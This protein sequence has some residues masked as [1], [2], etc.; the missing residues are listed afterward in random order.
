MGAVPHARDCVGGL[1]LRNFQKRAGNHREDRPAVAESM[2]DYLAEERE[3]VAAGRL[4]KLEMQSR[5][6]SVTFFS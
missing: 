6:V 4:S 2:K 5:G 1:P 3:A